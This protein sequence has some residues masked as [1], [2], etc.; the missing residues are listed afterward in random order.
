MKLKL[1]I[2]FLVLISALGVLAQ[3]PDRIQQHVRYLASEALEGRRT[4]TKGAM[5]A[6]R[7]IAAEFSRLGLKPVAA[8]A[9]GRGQSRYLQQFPYVAGVKLGKGNSLTLRAGGGQT[10]KLEVGVDWLPLAFSSSAKVEG[11]P[12][13][14]GYGIAAAE[15][16]HNDYAIPNASGRIAIALQDRKS[17]RLNSSHSQISYAVFC[18]KKK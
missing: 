14:V 6:A 1:T 8:S 10:S 11:L 3:Q 13:Y 5:E 12:A 4:G 7:Y 18:L 9:G 15:L 16:N 17:T 2:I